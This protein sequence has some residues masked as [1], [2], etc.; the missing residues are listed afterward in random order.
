MATRTWIIGLGTLTAL[1][2]TMCS[3]H[4]QNN[5]TETKSVPNNKTPESTKTPDTAGGV[6]KKDYEL[7]VLTSPD[8]K[9]GGTLTTTIILTPA[10]GLHVN[11]EYPHKITLSALPP[12]VE[13]A[14]TEFKKED[15]KKFTED[16]AEFEVSCTA[17]EGGPKEFQGEYRLSVCTD[18]YCATPKEKLA[19][20]FDVK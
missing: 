6:S 3:A 11:Q 5:T 1:A 19:W 12:G 17:K 9:V 2:L 4:P 14:K 16:S 8:A 10:A 13:C 20:K 18:S 15:A 7:A